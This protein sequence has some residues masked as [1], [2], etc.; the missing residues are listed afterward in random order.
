VHH[1][2]IRLVHME[3]MSTAPSISI[4]IVVITITGVRH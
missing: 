1:V 3:E 4:V 2:T